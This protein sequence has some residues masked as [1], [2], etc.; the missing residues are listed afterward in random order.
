[1]EKM[2]AISVKIPKE[3]KARMKKFYI[4][5]SKVV[6]AI[7]ERGI[8][9]EEARR[10]NEDIRKHKNIF[11]KLSVESVIEDLRYDRYRAH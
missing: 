8:L 9:E 11:D 2:V 4:K 5:P 3:M 7:L 10:L 1:M 6:R